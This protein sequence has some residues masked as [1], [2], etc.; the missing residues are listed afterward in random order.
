MS[1]EKMSLTTLFALR[2]NNNFHQQ[3]I[4]SGAG[5]GEHLS[6][7]KTYIAR[8]IKAV[9]WKIIEGEIRKK[10]LEALKVDAVGLLTSAWSKYKSLSDFVEKG[11][12]VGKT[13]H[14]PLAEHSI[15]AEMHPNLEIQ[16]GRLLTKRIVFDVE[17]ELKLKGL[18]LKIENGKIVEVEGGSCE[19]SG[20]IK[21]QEHSLVHKSFGPIHLPHKVHLGKEFQLCP[22]TIRREVLDWGLRKINR[23]PLRP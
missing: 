8:H 7:A 2:K 20:E 16:L 19:G 21:V 12:S 11:T 23:L 9:Q 13:A 10:T 4:A 17:L 3:V 5:K 1:S 22:H 15:T 18:V 14:L 6:G